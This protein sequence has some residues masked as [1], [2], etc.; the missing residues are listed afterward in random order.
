MGEAL[1]LLAKSKPEFLQWIVKHLKIWWHD[2]IYDGREGEE[3]GNGV[4][5]FQTGVNSEH[6]II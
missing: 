6:N 4:I 2:T 5:R 1:F 3:G